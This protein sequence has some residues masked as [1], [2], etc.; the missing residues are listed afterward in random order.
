MGLRSQPFTSLSVGYVLAIAY[1][2]LAQFVS[3]PHWRLDISTALGLIEFL[4][5]SLTGVNLVSPCEKR[6][7][8]TSIERSPGKRELKRND[9]EA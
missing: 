3:L 5:L 7:Q 1:L 4:L 2:S 8:T 6:A 9:L